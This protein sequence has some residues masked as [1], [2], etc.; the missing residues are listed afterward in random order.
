MA[1]LPDAPIVLTASP[2][3][4]RNGDVHHR[5]RQGSDF[6]WLTGVEQPGYAL[7]IDP[8]HAT[9]TL[10]APRLTQK[11]AVWLGHIPSLR[12][13]REAF[14]IRHVLHLDEL[15][16]ALRKLGRVAHVHADARS[17]AAVRRSRPAAR[18]ERKP[19]A[20]A[21][22][23]LRVVKD[24]AELALLRQASAATAAGHVAAMQAARAGQREYQVQ[25]VLECAFAQAGCGQTGYASIVAGGRNAAVLHYHANAARLAPRSLLLIDAGAECHGY[26]ADVTRTFPVSGRFTRFQRDVYDVVLAAQLR[27]IELAQ[28]GRTTIELQRAAEE[29][30]A[31]GLRGLGFLHGGTAELVDTKAVKIFFP[32]GISHSLGLDVH[33]AQGGRKRTLPQPRAAKLRFRARL[34]PGFVITVEPGV[35][36]IEA[37]LT[38]RTLRRSHRG[39]VDFDRAL[40]HLREGGVRIE[41]DVVV[42]PAGPPENLTRVP[43]T[44]ADVEAACGR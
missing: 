13:A 35:Y 33:D 41:D 43:R 29:T 38:D 21:L 26:G 27:C 14:G 25:A 32:H 39:R 2:E 11:H 42:R 16:K 7:L 24:A 10:F 19:L 36:F 31:E 5:Y 44:V 1:R 6:L 28:P 4:V 9:E 12:E 37:L 22:L 23:E 17:V 30:L 34:E 40:R 8:R 3:Q 15:P 20:E 18:V